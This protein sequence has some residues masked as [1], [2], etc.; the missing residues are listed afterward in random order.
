MKPSVV[1][2]APKAKRHLGSSLRITEGVSSTRA[3]FMDA[4]GEPIK[5][6]RI[7]VQDAVDHRRL[8]LLLV[9]DDTQGR[10]LGGSIGVAV[11]GADHEVVGAAVSEDVSQVVR[12]LTGDIDP[13]LFQGIGREGAV[14]ALKAQFEVVVDIRNPLRANLDES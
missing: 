13:V 1:G 9:P 3:I 12:T 11:I 4:S 5:R 7:G 8:D 6:A 2:F 10:D 14:L